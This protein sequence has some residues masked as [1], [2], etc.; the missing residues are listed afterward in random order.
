MICY[1]RIDRAERPACPILS[2]SKAGRDR[3]KMQEIWKPVVGFDGRYSVS[4]FG[5]VK[6]HRYGWNRILKQSQYKSGYMYV[7]IINK[8]QVNHK[9]GIKSDNRVENLEW[10]TA[11]ENQLHSLHVLKNPHAGK[12]CK[13]VICIDNG[14]IYNSISDAALEC[15]T[16]RSEIRKAIRRKGKAGGLRWEDA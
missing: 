14:K 4:N 10:A 15:K 2:S 12:P 7:Q 11:S 16:H 9:N 13:K 1:N 6:T 5:R 3:I 8:K